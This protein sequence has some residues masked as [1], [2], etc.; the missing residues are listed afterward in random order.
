VI[1]N[2][3]LFGRVVRFIV[4]TKFDDGRVDR[5]NF[6][7]ISDDSARKKQKKRSGRVGLAELVLAEL[8]GNPSNLLF[9]CESVH[10]NYFV[11]QNNRA[12]GISDFFMVPL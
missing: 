10:F 7:N 6:I 1:N 8:S 5:K 3:F 12:S 9:H 2:I 4:H 11:K